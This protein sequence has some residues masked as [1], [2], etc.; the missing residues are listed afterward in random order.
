MHLM[1]A[2]DG[3]LVEG[4]GMALINGSPCATALVA[5]V[6]LHAQHRLGVAEAIFALSIERIER[7]WT[8]TTRRSTI[9]G[10][11]SPNA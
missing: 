3:D 11:T 2:I 9:C 4:E 1:A 5:D 7:P 6:A 10:A 8:P